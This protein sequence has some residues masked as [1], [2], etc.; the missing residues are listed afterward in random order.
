MLFGTYVHVQWFCCVCR[1]TLVEA[2]D[3]GVPE[4]GSDL[5]LSLDV[6]SVQVI[7]DALLTNRLDRHLRK[8]TH[9]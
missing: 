6:N 1:L 9:Y 7:S 3:V 2:Y 4:R 5:D 8:K